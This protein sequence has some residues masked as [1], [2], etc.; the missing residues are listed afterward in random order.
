MARTVTLSTAVHI[1]AEEFSR[2]FSLG[3]TQ[4]L[5][6]QSAPLISM[7][8]APERELQ[9]RDAIVKALQQG[10]GNQTRAAR[11]LGMGRN[12]LWRK[13]KKYGIDS[14]Q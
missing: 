8:A 12:T 5:G 13:M 7:P 6:V 14:P 9:E 11:I 1:T 2:I 4:A 3:R 10:N